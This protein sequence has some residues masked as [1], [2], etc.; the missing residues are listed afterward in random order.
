MHATWLY[1]YFSGNDF[2]PYIKNEQ[3]IGILF[4][5]VPMLCSRISYLELPY[6]FTVLSTKLI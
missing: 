1:K 3:T 2:Y 6:F 5:I 4:F